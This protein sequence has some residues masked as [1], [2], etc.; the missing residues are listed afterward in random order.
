MAILAD[1]AAIKESRPVFERLYLD[2]NKRCYVSPDPLQFL[3]DFSDPRDIEIVGLI[4]SSLAYGRVNQI[5]KSIKRVLDALGSSPQDRLRNINEQELREKLSGFVH[6]FTDENEIVAFL[7]A[8]GSVLRQN[9]TLEGL[10]MSYYKGDTVLALEGFVK[11]LICFA[12]RDMFLLPRPSKG[13][14]CKRIA[15]FLRWMVRHDDVDMGIWKSVKPESLFVPL[16]THMFQICGH[17]GLCRGKSA[18]MTTARELT[19]S[20]RLISPSD[21][22]KYDFALTRFGIRGEMTYDDLFAKWKEEQ[23][24]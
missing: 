24:K 17:L 21:P 7:L 2:Y 18:N 11:E 19:D 8:V 20:F 15:L 10:F 23:D 4:A 6:R 3:Y 16:D 12:G 13:S 1:K 14:A 22:V 5:L 9:D